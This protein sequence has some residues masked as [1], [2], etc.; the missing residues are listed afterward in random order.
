MRASENSKTQQPSGKTGDNDKT[1][2]IKTYGCQMNV[3]DS[4]RMEEA[5]PRPAIARLRRLMR[6]IW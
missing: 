5:L 3:Y 2:F 4:Q 1:C 6:P